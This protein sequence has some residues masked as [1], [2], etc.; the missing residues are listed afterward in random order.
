MEHPYQDGGKE[1]KQ[2]VAAYFFLTFMPVQCFGEKCTDPA[3]LAYYQV[4]FLTILILKSD[5]NIYMTFL[6]NSIPIFLLFLQN[7]FD[8]ALNL[9]KRF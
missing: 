2:E 5:L 6:Q 4:R 3:V 9:K 1:N 7:P 8:K